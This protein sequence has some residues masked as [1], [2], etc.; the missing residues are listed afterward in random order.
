M[1][2]CS[3]ISSCSKDD[4]EGGNNR[5]PFSEYAV[6]LGLPSG[7][8]WAD[9]NVG[10]DSPED[11]GAYFAWGETKPKGE[12]DWSTYKWC[13]GSGA[14]TKY[15]TDSEYGYNGFTDGKTTLEP[16]DDA[17]TA[18]WGS[19]WCMPTR[20]QLL[21]LNSKCTW[22]TQNGVKGYKV[23]GLNGNSI[24]L[25]AAG[26]R[27]YSSLDD[28][29]SGGEYWSSSLSDFY[30]DCSCYLNFD[31]SNHGLGDYGRNFGRTVRAVVR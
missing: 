22:T 23:T 9:R 31:S 3:T 6:D 18:N 12:Y 7:T 8:L 15:C 29:G 26:C 1:L 10:A 28:A 21:E 5:F 14:M 24:F 16:S 19:K 2:F 20:D 4:D 27:Y 11:Y 13:K 17:A 30:P 25:P